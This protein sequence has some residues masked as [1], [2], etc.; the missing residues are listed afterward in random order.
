MD[1][2]NIVW[3]TDCGGAD[4]ENIMWGTSDDENIVW[5]TNDDAMNIIWGSSDLMNIVWGTSAEEDVTWG[6]SGDSDDAVVYPDD[7]TEP[8][9]SLE[10]EF[11]DIVGLVPVVQPVEGTNPTGGF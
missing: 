9:P 5:G 7:A 10:L 1:E 3:G 6:S 4:C 11:G 8:L 2:M